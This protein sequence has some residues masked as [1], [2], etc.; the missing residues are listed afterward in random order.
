[1]VG[2]LSNILQTEELLRNKQAAP[3]SA[4]MKFIVGNLQVGS[5]EDPEG[6][7]AAVHAVESG[8]GV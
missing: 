4:V 1:M 7:T 5:G 2:I 6:L 8:A 3:W